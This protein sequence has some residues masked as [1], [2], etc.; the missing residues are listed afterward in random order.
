M[1]NNCKVCFPLPLIFLVCQLDIIVPDERRRHLRK[2]NLGKMLPRTRVIASAELDEILEKTFHGMAPAEGVGAIAHTTSQYFSL[3]AISCAAQRSG[4]NSW[5]S[6][7]QHSLDFCMTLCTSR[8]SG[9]D[10]AAQKHKVPG[11]D[12]LTGDAPTTPYPRQSA[13]PLC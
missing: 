2:L 4:L 7:P 10:I 6:G 9:R 8:K 11:S 1:R 5:A 3:L 12:L 13:C